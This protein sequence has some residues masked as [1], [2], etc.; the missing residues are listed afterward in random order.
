MSWE[1]IAKEL[2][3]RFEI[4]R[5]PG[6]LHGRYKGSHRDQPGCKS[7]LRYRAWMQDEM[8]WLI[9]Q[10]EEVQGRGDGLQGYI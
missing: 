2:Q 10:S 4:T 7:T 3:N 9:S 6:A 8:E 1:Q 5:T